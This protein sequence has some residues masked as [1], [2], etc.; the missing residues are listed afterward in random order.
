M[1]NVKRFNLR[2]YALLIKGDKILLADES[3]NGFQFTKFPGGGLELGEGLIDG[4]KREL[5][6]EGNITIEDINHFYTTDF[7]QLSAFNKEDQIVSVYYKV[8]A[9]I[10]WNEFES[11]QSLPGKQ[12]NLRLYFKPIN[13]LQESDLT[14]PIDKLVMKI[15]G[16][17]VS[18]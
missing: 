14:F 17:K 7:F 1:S 15:P 5:I 11:D 13:E 16:F 2:V 8:K 9:N 18:L 4:L 3:I 12:H 6:E 10:D